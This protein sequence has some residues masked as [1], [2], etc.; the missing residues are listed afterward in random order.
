MNIPE[1]RVYIKFKSFLTHYAKLLLIGSVAYFVF[2]VLLVVRMTSGHASVI[3][4]V[5]ILFAFVIG[6]VYLLLLICSWIKCRS[7]ALWVEDGSLHYQYRRHRFDREMKKM[8]SGVIVNYVIA[9][10]S[11]Q[12][13]SPFGKYIVYMG[14]NINGSHSLA[15]Q[16]A[17]N[18]EE[19]LLEQVNT[20][21]VRIPWCFDL[22]E[23][24]GLFKTKQPSKEPQI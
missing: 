13:V 21:M 1:M 14:L 4:N 24:N 19:I 18:R 11:V 12:Y 2:I 3:G 9:S 5:L 20:V 10:D 15:V 6:C 8:S 17:G 7:I 22:E 23:L 16:S